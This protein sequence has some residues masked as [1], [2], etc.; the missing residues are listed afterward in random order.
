M[1][2]TLFILALSLALTQ[3]ATDEDPKKVICFDCNPTT[4]ATM[5]DLTGLDGC[6]FV[7]EINDSTRLEPVRTFYCGTPPFPK[8]NAPD[9]L[10]K[11][12]FLDGKKVLISYTVVEDYASAC[13]VGQAV[14]IMCIKEVLTEESTE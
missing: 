9:P 1:K 2:K 4:P 5:R 14:R 11:I 6:G 12:E 3:C 7:F 13:M 10:G 8:D